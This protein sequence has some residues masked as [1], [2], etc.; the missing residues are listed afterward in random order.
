MSQDTL[1]K[2]LALAE[3]KKDAAAELNIAALQ[4]KE[5][6]LSVLLLGLA[7]IQGSRVKRLTAIL[8]KLEEDIFDPEIIAHLSPRDKIETY[9]LALSTIGTCTNF[10]K[11]TVNSTDWTGVE[12]KM[13]SILPR[14]QETLAGGADGES[15]QN[16]RDLRDMASHLLK[17]L[18]GR[19]NG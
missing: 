17:E 1:D 2:G 4:I 16:S 13:Q 15:S 3:S 19:L 6:G 5:V 11:G 18:G 8:E 9:Q 7:E 10:I 14:L 12:I